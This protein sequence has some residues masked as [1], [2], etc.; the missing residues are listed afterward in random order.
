MD[1]LRHCYVNVIY[2]RQNPINPEDTEKPVFT[3][4]TSPEQLNVSLNTP[5]A[6]ANVMAFETKFAVSYKNRLIP[7]DSITSHL[8]HG[9]MFAFFCVVLSCIDRGLAMG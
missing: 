8:M 7:S 5:A 9:C 6:N 2:V 4:K 1:N 3:Y